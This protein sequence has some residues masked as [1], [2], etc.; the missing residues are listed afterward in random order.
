MFRTVGTDRRD[1]LERSLNFALSL[2]FERRQYLRRGRSEY[3]SAAL[4]F[5]SVADAAGVLAA[6][7]DSRHLCTLA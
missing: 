3:R 7:F 4:E 2:L 5:S 6:E 1:A